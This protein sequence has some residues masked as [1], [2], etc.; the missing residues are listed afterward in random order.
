MLSSI[1]IIF[2]EPSDFIT[3][4]SDYLLF[5]TV[6]NC[7]C[8]AKL[9]AFKRHYSNKASPY[10]HSY[11]SHLLTGVQLLGQLLYEILSIGAPHRSRAHGVLSVHN[12][13]HLE[14]HIYTFFKK[15]GLDYGVCFLR[16]D[17]HTYRVVELG[18]PSQ[19]VV[20]GE[21]LTGGCHGGTGEAHW[22]GATV[23]QV[24]LRGGGGQSTL[25]LQKRVQVSC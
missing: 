6:C 12:L 1:G 7:F 2:C 4:L 11:S 3:L 19:S 15:S 9:V 16:M 25:K 14:I 5:C 13:W 24:Q 20:G 17:E 18:P 10:F 23:V 8:E 21:P 22:A